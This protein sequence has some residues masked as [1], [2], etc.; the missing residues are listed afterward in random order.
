MFRIER[1]SKEHDRNSF[2]CGNEALND[3]LYKQAFQDIKKNVAIV[4]A[5]TDESKRVA[6]FYTL[7]ASS[8]ERRVIPPLT[9]KRLPKYEKIPAILLGR[10]AV[11]VN[12]QGQGLGKRLMLSAFERCISID[13]GWAFLVTD[14][15]DERARLF[16]LHFGFIPLLDDVDHLFVTK[17]TIM[18]A[19]K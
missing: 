11:S 18:E 10:L 9:T 3:Y 15:K 8:V 19:M 6:G 1:L 4:I 14:A 2:V 17:Q 16:Y 12:H 5:A 13:M 7:C